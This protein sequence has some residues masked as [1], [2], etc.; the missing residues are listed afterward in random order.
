MKAAQKSTD[1]GFTLIE[2]IMVFAILMV[3]AAF[4]IPML[5]NMLRGFRIDGDARSIASLI[6]QAKLRAASSFTHARVRADLSAKTYRLEVCQKTTPTTCNWQTEGGVVRLSSDVSF[7]LGSA[8]SS[9]PITTPLPTLAQAPLCRTSYAGNPAGNTVTLSDTACIEFNSRGVPSNPVING[10][11]DATE[12]FYITNGS[13][14]YGVTTKATG[15]VQT[16]YT[17]NSSTTWKQR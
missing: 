7:G 12:N 4:S 3:V 17:D 2:L 6:G 13:S 15:T 1:D 8:T 9:P 16:W 10:N 14:V 5:N 11:P